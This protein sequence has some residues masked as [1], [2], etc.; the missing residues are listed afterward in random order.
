M[1]VIQNI[2]KNLE[3]KLN[4]TEEI[5]LF[6]WSQKPIVEK[7]SQLMDWNDAYGPES[8][9]VQAAEQILE[10]NYPNEYLKY[11]AAQQKFKHTHPFYIENE[12]EDVSGFI[13]WV[14][15]VFDH[16]EGLEEG[17]LGGLVVSPAIDGSTISCEYEKGKLMRVLNKGDGDDAEMIV[18]LMDLGSI[19]SEISVKKNVAVR[20]VITLK[21]PSKKDKGTTVTAAVNKI[22]FDDK[23]D[24]SE[25]VFIPTEWL[26][27]DGK[28][29]NSS[30]ALQTLKDNGFQVPAFHTSAQVVE[31]LEK[32]EEYMG[33]DFGYELNGCRIEVEKG[34]T[35]NSLIGFMNDDQAANY[36]H[37][38]ILLG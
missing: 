3:F 35:I 25:L 6:K 10:L 23:A 16:F 12:V 20:G 15:G 8:I 37:K 24:D 14:N 32:Y 30:K 7:I 28:W 4:M 31:A 38:I 29:S 17:L 36:Y 2:F 33:T 26:T 18:N 19:P 27:V 21:N 11:S 13:E 22:M 9:V 5:K 1:A 34:S